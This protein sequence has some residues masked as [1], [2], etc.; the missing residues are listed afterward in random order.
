[1]A[2][3]GLLVDREGGRPYDRFRDRLMFPIFGG[4]GRPIAFGAR[5]LDGSEPKYLNSPET[6]VYKKREVLYGLHIARRAMMRQQ[7]AW[8]VE[9]YMDVLAL[10]QAGSQ[11]V[12][13]VSGTS[14]TES[15]ARALVRYAPRVMLLFDG[16]EAGRKAVVR[17]LP[18]LLGA[19]LGVRV[20]LLPPGE[21]PDSLVR[22]KGGE[23]VEALVRS[24]QSVVDFIISL[25]QQSFLGED[26][27]TGSGGERARRFDDARAA[28]L[29]QLVDLAGVISDPM[30]RRLMVQTA[31]R[32][33]DFD[34]TTLAAEVEAR[35]RGAA[36]RQA[37]PQTR[38]APR[39]Q[40]PAATDRRWESLFSLA[41]TDS[42]VMALVRA[43]LTVESVPDGPLRALWERLI[44]WFD[45]HGDVTIADLVATVDSPEDAAL[46]SRLAAR[47]V[48]EERLPAAREL[49]AALLGEARRRQIEQLKSE[50]RRHERSG[51]EAE[52]RRLMARVQELIRTEGA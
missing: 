41:I 34:E 52:V 20:A 12:V 4:S 21:D 39:H 35:R 17:S 47:H 10:W 40:P 37:R 9:G 14:L 44:Q 38:V 27:L 3:A 5:S 26:G 25:C 50:I 33:L 36:R 11:H 23:A 24:G 51:E 45:T 31:A 15:Q 32:Q 48:P 1:L 28:A 6:P 46:L 16:D 43:E 19:G 22:A 30:T 7:A 49:M 42:S 2:Q 18:A 29:G 8:V 13:A